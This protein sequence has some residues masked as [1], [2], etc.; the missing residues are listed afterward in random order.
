MAAAKDILWRN[1]NGDTALWNANG[2]GGFTCQDL[3]V[4]GA[5]WQVAGTGDFNGDG[6]DGILWRNTNGDTALWNPNG[7]GGFSLGPGR[8]RRRLA[9]RRNRRLQRER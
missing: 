7:S 1:S 8:R 4:V 5:T 9:D 6:E 3:G 2:T